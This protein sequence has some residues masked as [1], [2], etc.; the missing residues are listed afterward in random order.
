M[1]IGVYIDTN[2]W[3]FRFEK[4]ELGTVMNIDTENPPALTKIDSQMIRID[5]GLITLKDE[6]TQRYWTVKLRPFSMAKYTVTREE[7][8]LVNKDVRLAGE[9]RGPIV[10]ISWNDAVRFC[11]SL[12]RRAGLNECYAPD[13]D[14]EI[15]CD[16]TAHGYRLPTEAEWE[17]ACRA[18]TNDPRYGELDAIAWYRDNSAYAVHEVGT[19]QPNAWGFHDMI[20][21][22]WEW[23]W[24]MFDQQVYGTYR[25]FRGG[26][27]SDPP[28]AC[29]A[30]CRR[31]S[32]PNFHI[33]DL[34][35]R[36]AR[37]LDSQGA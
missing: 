27:W 9:S 35:F 32:H 31:K 15:V 18:G 20:G 34:G 12:S 30:S 8:Q 7:Y 28:T 33:D 10:D 36:L 1:P 6:G 11:N 3:D 16:W 5:G 17:Y 26:S 29:R 25:V 2:V 4:N 13:G 23:C 14:G 22:V 24:D 37:S 21:N 19:K